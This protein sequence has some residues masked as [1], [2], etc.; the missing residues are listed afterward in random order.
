MANSP[1]LDL[2]WS[3]TLR[4]LAAALF[5]FLIT[6]VFTLLETYHDVRQVNVNVADIIAKQL[7]VQLF[8]IDSNIEIPSRFPDWDPVSEQVQIPGQCI[9]FIRSD[10][11]LGRSSCLGFNRGGGIPPS[12]FSSLGTWLLA[13]RTDVARPI[14]YHGKFPGTLVVTTESTAVV[15]AIWK[16]VSGLLGF[17][18]LVIGAICV[19]QYVAIGRALRPTKDILVG[20]DKLALGDLSSRLPNFRLIELQ[21]I[22]E[23]FNTLAASLDQTTRERT[24]LA[25]KLVD[26][27]EQERR[28]LA[29]ELHDELAQTLSVIS[30]GAASIRATAEAQ[31]PALVPEADNLSQTSMAMMRS[32][33]ITLQ[34]LRPPE[35]DDFGLAAS[36]TALARDQERRAS[37]KLKISLKIDGDLQA[38]PA[39]LASH[40]YRIVQEGLTNICKHANASLARVELSFRREAGKEQTTRH[41]RWLTLTIEDN[42]YG[43][44]DPGV[45][46]EASRLGLI[47]MRERVMAL[48]GQLNVI[49]LPHQ[50]LKLHV[51]IPFET[52]AELIQ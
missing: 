4:V 26:G 52:P 25:A 28:H 33:R 41:R 31:C 47:G 20:L 13:T 7:Q 6:A 17:T 1:N 18:A 5:C 38:L 37:G 16:E 35:I 32:L 19:M 42:G 40:V 27:Q 24:A 30:A 12:W 48:G 9:Q 21:R 23:V 45:A 10:G 8:R 15:A 43:R 29:R 34:T 36:L 50:G 39:T 49:N 51:M 3:L 22:S 2:R 11:S 14:S 46:E 44:V